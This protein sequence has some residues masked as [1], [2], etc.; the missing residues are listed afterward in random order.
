M[1]LIGL[2]RADRGYHSLAGVQPAGISWQVGYQSCH[3]QPPQWQQVNASNSMKIAV[4]AWLCTF[5]LLADSNSKRYIELSFLPFS[6]RRAHKIGA[7]W[8]IVGLSLRLNSSII[9]F[10][11]CGKL[12][13][14]DIIGVTSLI[15]GRYCIWVLLL[16]FVFLWCWLVL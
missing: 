2:P 15:P 10:F 1:S 16:C 12:K 5:S 14:S 13:S 4:I 3:T 8:G 9:N 6:N 11:L 7:T